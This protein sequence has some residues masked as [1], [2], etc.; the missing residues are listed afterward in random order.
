MMPYKITGPSIPNIESA[1]TP[2][3]KDELISYIN[4]NLTSLDIYTRRYVDTLSLQT[5]LNAMASDPRFTSANYANS[6]IEDP[7]QIFRWRS[8][9]QRDAA[10]SIFHFWKIR[11]YLGKHTKECGV[12][13]KA[14]NRELIKSANEIFSKEF[15]DHINIRDF[16]SH[17]AEQSRSKQ[18][19]EKHAMSGS[20]KS[21]D[22]R[23]S[24]TNSTNIF[25]SVSGYD[26][27]LM[28][29]NGKP[30]TFYLT[31]EKAQHLNGIR[32]MIFEAYHE[33]AG[34]L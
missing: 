28:T 1:K 32:N 27:F 13:S 31:N 26:H 8:I 7:E 23:F 34:K 3:C 14:I 20:Y 2:S 19:T 18:D 30:Y 25:F 29:R 33:A 11:E 21:P 15:G 9:A 16:V 12:L 5:S 4:S 22:G 17:E 24:V 6:K 10:M